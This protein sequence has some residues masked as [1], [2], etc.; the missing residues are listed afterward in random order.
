MPPKASNTHETGFLE[1]IDEIIGTKRYE[2]P[3]QR[4]KERMEELDFQREEK[5]QRVTLAEQHKN[6]MV[7]PMKKATAYLRD[8]N[9]KIRSHHLLNQVKAY[10]IRQG[11]VGKKEKVKE[12]EE[13]RNGIQARLDEIKKY[14]DEKRHEYAEAEKAYQIAEAKYKKNKKAMDDAD[15]KYVQ[16]NREIK[17]SN[18]ERKKKLQEIT[19][20]ETE[21]EKLHGL[22]E[23]HEAEIEKLEK[24]KGEL[25]ADI[26]K[27]E[28]AVQ[29]DIA[30]LN[31][32]V[33]K[34]VAEKKK[35][36]VVF[37]KVKSAMDDKKAARDTMQKELDRGQANEAAEKEKLA[38]L[39]KDLQEL[40]NKVKRKS[41]QE[42]NISPEEISQRE[43]EAQKLKQQANALTNTEYEKR[44]VYMNLRNQYGEAKD[45]ADGGLMTDRV[46]KALF[47]AKAQ[48]SFA[49]LYGRLKDLATID[50]KYNIGA[51]VASGMLDYWVVNDDSTGA[52][53]IQ[54]L[55]DN[56]LQA[57]T[58]VCVSKMGNLA[59][60]C[61]QPFRT[62]SNSLRIFDQLKIRNTE[63]AP[64]FYKAFR[65]TLVSFK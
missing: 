41:V 12:V 18:E 43:S 9:T 60:V 3:L 34:A 38:K 31:K 24:R 28:E 10:H 46:D 50:E 52:D 5:S 56:R 32:E 47:A 2:K 44:S 26:Q 39:H 14:N 29:D 30:R 36:D 19:K 16:L 61:K 64:V 17:T 13:H 6:A 42:L 40:E 48:G 21:L 22:P 8:K 65:D 62:P 45:T 7:E 57:Q 1:F 15:A 59:H 25:E 23:R 27:E 11:L 51:T 58:F 20:V 53:C 54:F 33:E 63:L 35:A 55:K 37:R 49:G 4:L